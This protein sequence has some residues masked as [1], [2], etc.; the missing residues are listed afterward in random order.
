[1][2]ATQAAQNTN[3]ETPFGSLGYAITGQDA[4][5]NPIYTATSSLSPEQQAI[6]NQLQTS[7]TGLGQAGGN[8]V[9]D[10]SSLYSQAPDFSEAAGTQTKINM[11]RQ[12]GYLTPYFTQQNDQLDNQLRNQGLMPGSEAYKRAMRS[13]QDNQNQSVMSFLNQTQGQSFDQA[14]KQYNQ[15]LQTLSGILGL[16]QPASLPQNLINTPK[17]SLAG[18]DVAGITNAAYQSNLEAYKAKL[19]QSNSMMSGL[20]GIGTSLL[21]GGL[22]GPLA[23]LFGSMGSS[24]AMGG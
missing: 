3:Q 10:A 21:T 13:M 14:Q 16:T 6:L 1:M 19:A 18:T 23:G 17:P 22:G 12:L 9:Q 7:Q 20:F 8:L 15:P 4:A 2:Q 5:G 11:D 24:M